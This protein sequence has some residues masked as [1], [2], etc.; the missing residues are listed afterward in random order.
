MRASRSP[1]GSR[2]RRGRPL[3][4]RQL[5]VTAPVAT[6]ILYRLAWRRAYERG[7]SEIFG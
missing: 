1:S 2:R 5:F 7:A 6:R 3:E 4:R